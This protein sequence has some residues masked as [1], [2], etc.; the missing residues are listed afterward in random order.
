MIFGYYKICLYTHR[1]KFSSEKKKKK[2]KSPRYMVSHLETGS[3]PLIGSDLESGRD[4]DSL[5]FWLAL[6]LILVVAYFCWLYWN[7]VVTF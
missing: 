4:I 6:S 3:D 1:Y 7:Y 5:C 2:V